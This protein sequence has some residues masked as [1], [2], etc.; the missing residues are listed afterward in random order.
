MFEDTIGGETNPTLAY[1]AYLKL[2]ERYMWTFGALCVPHSDR[3]SQVM[4]LSL[5]DAW[6]WLAQVINACERYVLTIG[7]RLVNGLMVFG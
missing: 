2:A 1:D 7:G 5:D 6:R 4:M 3:R